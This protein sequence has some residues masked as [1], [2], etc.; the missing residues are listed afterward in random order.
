ML[1]GFVD[2]PTYNLGKYSLRSFNKI[3]GINHLI[4]LLCCL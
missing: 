3:S 4:G 2:K 1:Q